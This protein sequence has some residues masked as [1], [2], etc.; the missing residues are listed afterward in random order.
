MKT[1]VYLDVLIT[2]Y[3]MPAQFEFA[4]GDLSSRF[5]GLPEGPLEQIL[6][7]FCKITLQ[8]KNSTFQ[9]RTQSMQLVS[10]DST[11]QFKFMKNK[12]SVKNLMLHI[13]ALVIHISTSGVAWGS[14]IAKILKKEQKELQSYF[15]ELG[16][17]TKDKKRDDK[18]TGE[19]V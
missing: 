12:E 2:L 8:D 3:R 5:R 14:F 1:F 15:R 6:Q 19:K 4:M 7:K 13:I 18:R 9:K 11:T 16:A 10:S 17:Y